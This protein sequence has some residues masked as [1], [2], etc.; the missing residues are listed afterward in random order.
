MRE[1]VN[2]LWRGK[3]MRVPTDD[4]WHLDAEKHQDFAIAKLDQLIELVV[5]I[6]MAWIDSFVAD[7]VE[8]EFGLCLA[9]KE[10]YEDCHAAQQVKAEVVVFTEDEANEMREIAGCWPCSP[11]GLEADWSMNQSPPPQ[12]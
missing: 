5:T 10:S 8:L 6:R 7:V 2:S 12:A 9:C 4:V 11:W 1:L 3:L